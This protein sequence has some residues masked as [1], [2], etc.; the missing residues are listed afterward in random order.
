MIGQL[1]R[2]TQTK[3]DVSGNSSN[4]A[5]KHSRSKNRAGKAL[6]LDFCIGGS[7]VEEWWWCGVRAL[8]PE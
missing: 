6:F 4:L 2:Q 3:M 1:K 5:T 7:Y 8:V